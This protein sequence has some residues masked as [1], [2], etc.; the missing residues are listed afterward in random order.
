MFRVWVVAALVAG[1]AFGKE[2]LVPRK[3]WGV[4]APVRGA[5]WVLLGVEVGCL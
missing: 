2:H 5:C 4:G 1:W 3:V